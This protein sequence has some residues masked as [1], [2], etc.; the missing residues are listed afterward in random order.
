VWEI[1][2]G[3]NGIAAGFIFSTVTNSSI[4]S[5][6]ATTKITISDLLTDGLNNINIDVIKNLNYHDALNFIEV[7]IKLIVPGSEPAGARQ[8]ELSFT[9]DLTD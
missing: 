4:S 9:W 6:L 3:V 1:L 7:D 2:A 8:K 5:A